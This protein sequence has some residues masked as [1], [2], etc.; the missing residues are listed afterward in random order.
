[1]EIPA[2]RE[3]IEET[4]RL[5]PPDV[6]EVLDVG[7]GNGTFLK[8]LPETCVKIG[9]DFSKEAL[10]HVPYP[11]VLANAE[12]LPFESSSF[13]LVT[14]LEVLEHLPKHIFEAT[15]SE[16]ARVS[17]RYVIV[18]VPNREVLARSFLVCPECGCMFHRSRHLRTFEPESMFGLLEPGFRLKLLREIGPWD[19]RYP[20]MLHRLSLVVTPRAFSPFAVCPQCGHK[21]TIDHTQQSFSRRGWIEHVVKLLFRP[22]RVRRWLLALYEK[23]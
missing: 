4:V 14:C 16:L 10:K 11:T 5:V 13:D 22:Q 9:L 6:R 18:S 1:M 2:E 3:R 8:A 19:T 23:R 15:L 17:R 20:P 7:C 12:S 21:G